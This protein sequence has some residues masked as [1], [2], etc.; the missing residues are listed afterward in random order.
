[1]RPAASNYVTLASV[2]AVIWLASFASTGDA[3]GLPAFPGAEGYGA[4]TAGGRGGRVIA[5]TNL[6]AKGPGS[7]QAAC[8]AEGRRIVVFKVAGTIDGDIRIDNDH[9]TIAGQTAPGDGI[10]IKGNLAIRASDLVIRYLRIRTDGDGDAVSGRYE[11]NIILD[12]LSASWGADEVLSVYH[13]ENVTIQNCIISESIGHGTSHRFAAIWGSQYSSH[14]RNLIAHCDSRN[15]RWAS[16]CG[17]ADYRNNVLYNWGYNSCYGGEAH[18]VGDRRRPP[19]EFSHINMVA[20][21]Y[22]PGPA[23]HSKVKARIA[24]PSTRDGAE[25]AGKWWVAGNIVEGSPSVTADNW[26][27]VSPSGPEFRLDQ[28]WPAK[29]I[30]QQSAEEAYETVLDDVGCS[31]PKRDTVDTRIVEEVRN[32][33]A[34]YGNGI[35]TNPK[36][37]GGWP[38]LDNAT[39]PT[40]SDNDGMPDEWERQFGFNPYDES[41]NT[42]DKDEDGYTNIE[43]YLNGTDPI[44]FVDYT[45]PANNKNTLEASRRASGEDAQKR[46]TKPRVV[47]TSDGEIDDECSMVRFLLYANEW[48]IEAIVTSSSQYH[49]QGHKWA[50][51]DWIEPYLAAYAQVYP[52]LSKHDAAFPTPDFLRSRTALGNVKSEG[53]M[54]E[55]T[56][57][58]QLIVKVLLD[59]S[60]DRPIWLQAWGGP[61]TIARALKTIEVKH[62]EKMAAVAKKI[63]FF[64]IWEQD[65]TYQT[66]IR[67]NWG[68]YNI[69]TI[70]SDQ[71]IAFAY[72]WENILPESTHAVLRSEWMC[73]HILND[74]GPLCSLYKAHDDGR[75]RSEGDSPAFMHTIPVGLRSVESPDWGGWGGRYVRAREN[76]WLDP[77][78]EPGYDYPEGRWYTANAWGRSRM[79]KKITNDRELAIYLKP[80]WR[81]FH[82]IQNDFAARA[83]WCVKPYQQANHPPIVKLEHARDLRVRVGE[84][85]SLSAKGTTDPDGNALTYR[86]WQFVEADSAETRVRIADANSPLASFVVPDERGKQVHIVLE[87]TD[88]GSPPLARYQRVVCEIQD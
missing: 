57:G 15:P 88:N 81:W 76:T 31:L 45:K 25:D 60:D 56:D 43:E 84:S 64:F 67:P 83:D 1:M 55:E 18:Q 54:E 14:H 19:I 66:Y 47:V 50:G 3:L 5:V 75:F 20:N 68:K 69:P 29:A 79:R 37:V 80:M 21:Y 74:H 46:P 7:L 86:W 42:H 58:S 6:N 34:T 59:E 78:L 8:D 13:C 12:H 23:T 16:G 28:P 24:N 53:D 62:S 30:T 4:E 36:D 44:E 87:V 73:R 70:I 10:T 77:V 38:E 35:I 26:R 2:G 85:V 17:F 33:T 27:G 11:K 63:R 41:D 72:H 22:K 9:I 52:N 48:D 49:W 65:E 40:D 32:G 51:D 82:A 61:N 39:A 71:F